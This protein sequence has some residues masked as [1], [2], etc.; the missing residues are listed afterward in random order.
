MNKLWIDTETTGLDPA[1]HGVIEIAMV[2]TTPDASEVLD[3]YASQ[4]ELREDLYEVDADAL[5]VNGYSA[6]KWR[7]AS[8]YDDAFY[9]ILF[10]LN[11]RVR[12]SGHNIAFDRE[13]VLGGLRMA[14]IDIPELYHRTT[15]TQALAD[16]LEVAGEV[17]ATSLVC[18]AEYFGVDY[19]RPHSALCDIETTIEVYRR[20]LAMMRVGAKFY[21]IDKVE[22]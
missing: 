4:I 17:P 16:P 12:L 14:C 11:D 10:R 13:M 20:L 21:S 18:L 15:D 2:L 3:T 5:R 1:R 7:S 6:A 19:D 8:R 22:C 9:Q